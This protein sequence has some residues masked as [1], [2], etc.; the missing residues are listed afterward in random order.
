MAFLH[1]LGALVLGPAE[2]RPDLTII[3]VNDSGGGI[4]SLLEPGTDAER[5]DA[6]HARFERLFGTPH[7]VDLGAVCQGLGVPHAVVASAAGL[8]E[9]LAQLPDGLQVLEVRIDRED[10]VPVHEAIQRAVRTAVD[11]ALPSD[12]PAPGGPKTD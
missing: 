2:R 12:R 9:R 4:F 5:D 11:D 10:L 7:A 6:A 3:V 1:D 8:R